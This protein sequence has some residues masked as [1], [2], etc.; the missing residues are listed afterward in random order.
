MHIFYNQKEVFYVQTCEDTLQCISELGGRVVPKEREEPL[1]L[2]LG[3]AGEEGLALDGVGTG[4][5]AA[6]QPGSADGGTNGAKS[7]KSGNYVA[8]A[9]S[10]QGRRGPGRP[11]RPRGPCP[12]LPQLPP[13]VCSHWS[14]E[15]FLV[16]GVAPLSLAML[17][18]AGRKRVGPG[19]GSHRPSR[20]LPSR[21]LHANCGLPPGSRAFV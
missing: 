16:V 3:F 13:L 21:G 12:L 7:S 20:T 2:D 17:S 14:A 6:V 19:V 4:G 10:Q 15:P 11:Q 18:V 5:S 1:I 8:A 9:T